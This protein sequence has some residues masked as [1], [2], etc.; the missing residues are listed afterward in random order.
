MNE[1][2]EFHPANGMDCKNDAKHEIKHIRHGKDYLQKKYWHGCV[3]QRERKKAGLRRNQK[4]IKRE[5]KTL[6]FTHPASI[7][8][9]SR[10]HSDKEALGDRPWGGGREGAM[11]VCV[12]VKCLW[13]MRERLLDSPIPENWWRMREEINL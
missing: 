12:D 6:T 11:G 13:R 3:L 10:L 8:L 7:G 1:L 2:W 5:R 9:L 4:R